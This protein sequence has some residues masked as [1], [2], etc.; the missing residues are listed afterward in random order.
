M[1][2]LVHLCLVVV[3]FVD[4]VDFMRFVLV[5]TVLGVVVGAVHNKFEILTN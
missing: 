5:G 2:D 3:V 4:L 1:L